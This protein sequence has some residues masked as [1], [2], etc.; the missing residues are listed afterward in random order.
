[1]KT[2]S[3]TTAEHYS[4]HLAPIY[5][6]RVGDFESACDSQAEFFDELGLR[7]STSGI[8]VDLGCGHGLQ[9]VPLAQRGFK[10]VAVDTSQIL[11]DELSE[12]SAG[13][14]IRIIR[15]DLLRFATHVTSP[16]D[17]I[18][19]MGD[20]LT[21]L[22]SVEEVKGLLDS[23]ARWLGPHGSLILSFRDYA[24]SELKGVDRFIPVR[25]D[26][27]R[28]HT[29]F[30]ESVADV[31]HVHDII[32][33]RSSDGWTMAVS[34]YPKLKLPPSTVVRRATVAGLVLVHQ[35]NRRG[36]VH[37]AFQAE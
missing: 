17:V 23:A 7:P 11:L 32:H 4:E 10:V 37:L 24:S 12:R 28:I 34:S 9:S 35:S 25:S 20:T 6:W 13:L 27:S 31:V 1:M 26:E 29:C 19:C 16:V 33:T 14:R 3:R 2:R 30:L 15:E 36:M 18:L 5:S 22:P 8:A 21:H